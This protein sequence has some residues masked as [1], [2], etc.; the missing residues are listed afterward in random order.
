MEQEQ[1]RTQR[2]AP[3]EV[4]AMEQERT[5]VR[6]LT[7][8]EVVSEALQRQNTN[9]KAPVLATTLPS[10]LPSPLP[11]PL[12]T[13]TRKAPHEV[14]SERQQ[15]P[16]PTPSPTPS[17]PTPSPTPSQTPTEQTPTVQPYGGVTALDMV[18]R[19]KTIFRILRDFFYS[20]YGAKLLVTAVELAESL[21]RYPTIA[22]CQRA[23][24]DGERHR[25]CLWQWC[26]RHEEAIEPFL[27][28]HWR[29]GAVGSLVVPTRQ[30]LKLAEWL[31]GWG[32]FIDDYD[33][34]IRIFRRCSDELVALFYNPK[35]EELE[36][37][38]EYEDDEDE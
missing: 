28:I 11:T 23:M 26:R 5:Q 35:Y 14:V 21:G 20:G 12:P 30:G 9:A 36:E 37:E 31:S 15:K 27:H 7:P 38:L 2:K 33:G 34:C 22:E 13:P 18:F 17:P 10:P 32:R 24:F 8:H 19:K 4:A 6:Q 25:S 3:H 1:E 29:R 16:S